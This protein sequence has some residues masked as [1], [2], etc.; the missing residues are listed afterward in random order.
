MV[1]PETR[2]QALTYVD[3]AVIN[4]TLGNRDPSVDMYDPANGYVIATDGATYTSAF[5]KR[6]TAAQAIRNQD[7]ISQ[8]LDLL[9][10]RRIQTGNPNDLGDAIPF[11]VVGAIAA[12]CCV[13]LI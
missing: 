3:P 7:L 13:S 12:R 11:T 5:I 2:S 1:T 8:A 9:Q 10:Q 6:Y 4:N